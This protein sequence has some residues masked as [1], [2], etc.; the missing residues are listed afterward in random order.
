MSNTILFLLLGLDCLP[1][2]GELFFVFVC[3]TGEY[4]GMATNEFRIDRFKDV[5]KREHSQIVIDLGDHDEDIEDIPKFFA[6]VIVIIIIDC[7]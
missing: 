7:G 5:F 3:L 2:G 6:N 1:L 4:M